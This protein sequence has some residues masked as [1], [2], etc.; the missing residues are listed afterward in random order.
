MHFTMDASSSTALPLTQACA[1]T[2]NAHVLR[3]DQNNDALLTC[4]R[5]AFDGAYCTLTWH[6]P[7]LTSFPHVWP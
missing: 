7:L 6:K 5:R 4:C 1:P 2:V 3:L